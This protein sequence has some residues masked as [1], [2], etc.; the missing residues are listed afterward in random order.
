MI[1]KYAR[2][3]QCRARRAA[4]RASRAASCEDPETTSP[5]RRPKKDCSTAPAECVRRRVCRDAL[6]GE[7]EEEDEAIASC[8]PSRRAGELARVTKKRDTFNGVLI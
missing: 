5:T 2:E 4:T 7:D 1:N 8:D 3:K 6:P